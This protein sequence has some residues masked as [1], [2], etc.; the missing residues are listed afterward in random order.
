MKSIS[1]LIVCL[2]ITTALTMSCKQCIQTASN[3]ETKLSNTTVQL[4]IEQ[5]INKTVCEHLHEV[6][7]DICIQVIEVFFPKILMEVLNRDTPIDICIHL[8]YCQNSTTN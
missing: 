2:F 3:V 5:Y 6:D 1:G 4:Q 8:G 7:K